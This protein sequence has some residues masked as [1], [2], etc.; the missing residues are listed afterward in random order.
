MVLYQI[1]TFYVEIYYLKYRHTICDIKCSEDV[2]ILDEYLS[3][4]NVDDAMKS[5]V[6]LK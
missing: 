4:V 1:D 2:Q 3:Q 6:R 5:L